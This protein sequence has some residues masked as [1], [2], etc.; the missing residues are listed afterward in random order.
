MLLI[1][2]GYYWLIHFQVF[3]FRLDGWF[4]L[5][6][7]LSGGAFFT[8][9]FIYIV[10]LF[11]GRFVAR[12]SNGGLLEGW[13]L[14]REVIFVFLNYAGKELQELRLGFTG[15]YFD[16]GGLLDLR[17]GGR[18]RGQSG[19]DPV[20]GSFQSQA[21]P[22]RIVV[23]QEILE[24]FAVVEALHGCI[25]PGFAAFEHRIEQFDIVHAVSLQARE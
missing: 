6:W 3:L 16:G 11:D 8:V 18:S 7:N 24:L 13:F 17:P 25:E 22:L 4:W 14:P 12:Y 10:V 23:G 2:R 1:C 20:E 5:A 15:I 9:G 19:I 21:R